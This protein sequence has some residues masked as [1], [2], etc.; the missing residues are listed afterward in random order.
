MRT[1]F[2]AKRPYQ[3]LNTNGPANT[4]P[5]RINKLSCRN[6]APM[7]TANRTSR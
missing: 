7:T 6:V 2:S 1:R 5:N 4:V 3:K